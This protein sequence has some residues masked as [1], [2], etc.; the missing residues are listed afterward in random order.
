MQPEK[1]FRLGQF[2]LELP[3]KASISS[4]LVISDIL[5]LHYYAG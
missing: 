1:K 2:S 5:R 3:K 4:I